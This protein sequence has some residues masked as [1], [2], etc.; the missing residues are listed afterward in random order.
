MGALKV[1]CVFLISAFIFSFAPFLEPDITN[2]DTK[3]QEYV[4]GEI[5]S[6]HTSPKKGKSLEKT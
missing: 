1:H 2:Q 5:G 4:H 6:N 3:N